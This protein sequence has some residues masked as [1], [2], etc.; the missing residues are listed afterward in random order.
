MFEDLKNV[1]YVIEPGTES[2]R[3]LMNGEHKGFLVEGGTFVTLPFYKAHEVVT[4]EDRAV[5]EAVGEI[6]GK[7]V[8][9]LI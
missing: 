1:G 4:S 5:C 6:V 2:Q 3:V 9:G 7:K 8:F